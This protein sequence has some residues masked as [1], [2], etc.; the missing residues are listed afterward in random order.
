MV[1]IDPSQLDQILVNVAANARDAMPG[2]GTLTIEI[3]TVRL[4][5]AYCEEHLGFQPGSY[6]MLTITDSGN[7]IQT[8][9]VR[10]RYMAAQVARNPP[11]DVVNCP[12]LR[13]R[14]GYRNAATPERTFFGSLIYRT[15][16]VTVPCS[17]SPI[18]GWIATT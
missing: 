4:G 9:I 14:I 8:D 6:V 12:R 7:V 15:S 5:A 17:R 10:Q 3:E 16:V 1:H 2:G 13:L 11:N 18:S